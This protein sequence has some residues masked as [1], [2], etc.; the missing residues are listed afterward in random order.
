MKNNKN[1]KKEKRIVKSVEQA[2]TALS[3][4]LQDSEKLN[5]E[6]GIS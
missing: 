5:L 2:K 6:K 3:M 1:F 4:L